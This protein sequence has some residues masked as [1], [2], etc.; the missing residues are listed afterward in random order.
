MC[1]KT[2]A[3]TLLILTLLALVSGTGFLVAKDRSSWPHE[4]IVGSLRVHADFPLRDHVELLS[5]IAGLQSTLHESLGV[6]PGNQWIHVYFFRDKSTYQRYV[7]KYFPQAPLRRALFM[8]GKGPGMVFAYASGDCETDL[9]HEAT[10]ALL[11]ASLPM[12]PLW[13]DEGL[14]E[15]FELEPN[16]RVSG[17]PHLVRMRRSLWSGQFS[18]LQKLEVIDGVDSMDVADY[19]RAWAW[20]HFMLHGPPEA[21]EELI[22]FL[23]D[24]AA[25]SPPGQLSERLSRRI[26]DLERSF[27]THFST[28]RPN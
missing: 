20:V 12:V 23:K 5:D 4:L 10:H 27:V 1:R 2:S 7:K 28:W 8:K 14:A 19:R 3:K 15:Y 9:R 17:N 18:R 22:N 11:H 24:I 25:H 16:R 6:Q 21:R 13:L 26:P